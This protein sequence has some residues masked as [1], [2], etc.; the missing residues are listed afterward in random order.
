MKNKVFPAEIEVI[1]TEDPFGFIL[2]SNLELRDRLINPLGYESCLFFMP[3][4]RVLIF[5]EIITFCK[6]S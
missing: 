4:F 2:K 5:Y 1:S 6:I 3:P